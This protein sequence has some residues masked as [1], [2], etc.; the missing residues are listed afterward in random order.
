MPDVVK[1]DSHHE[2][3]R[4]R[5]PEYTPSTWCYDRNKAIVFPLSLHICPR[6]TD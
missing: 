5:I 2:T 6:K 4:V 1:F 3:C